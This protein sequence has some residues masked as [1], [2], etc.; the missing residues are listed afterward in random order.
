VPACNE[1]SQAFPA[2]GAPQA[3]RRSTAD[4]HRHASPAGCTART[5]A[6]HMSLPSHE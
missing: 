6:R 3:I 5:A 4:A 2:A 1:G